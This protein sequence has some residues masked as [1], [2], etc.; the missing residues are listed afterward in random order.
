M[1]LSVIVLGYLGSQFKDTP[2]LGGSQMLRFGI[3]QFREALPEEI[4]MQLLG[5]SAG[6]RCSLADALYLGE[7]LMEQGSPLSVLS[8][9]DTQHY[10]LVQPVSLQ[11]QRD[12]VFLSEIVQLSAEEYEV[13]SDLFNQH[14]AEEGIKFIQST[15]QQYWF[16]ELDAALQFNTYLAQKVLYQDVHPFKLKGP[17]AQVFNKIMNEAQMLLYEHPINER[18]LAQEKAA[19]NSVWCSG[20]GQFSIDPENRISALVGQGVLIEG[21][22]TYCQI[23]LFADFHRLKPSPEHALML[24]ETM[25]GVDWNHLF[26][27]VKKRTVN[28]LTI[29]LPNMNHTLQIQLSHWDCWKFWKRL[30]NLV[31]TD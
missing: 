27:M 30:P 12:R 23:P 25:D 19:V 14:F 10:L 5:A 16:V 18:R 3:S 13:L 26:H 1:N 2:H 29:Y 9:L 7:H 6:Q 28:Q 21:L 11:V 4:L 24:S 15:T 22:A 8:T 17:D 31:Q 20:N